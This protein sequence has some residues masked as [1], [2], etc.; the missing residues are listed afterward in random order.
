MLI[1]CRES[2]LE[3]DEK[4]VQ[5][6][7]NDLQNGGLRRRGG[8]IEMGDWDSDDDDDDADERRRRWEIR[9]E[10]MKRR[11][12]EDENLGRLGTSPHLT[13]K[14][15]LIV[16]ANPKAQAFLNAI[17]STTTLNFDDE[18]D[19]L[20]ES[21]IIEDTRA[22]TLARTNSM[23]QGDSQSQSQ[24]ADSLASQ[25]EV[26]VPATSSRSLT[27]RTRDLQ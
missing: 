20:G 23:P 9:R 14:Y 2:E 3:R 6:L 11:M 22:G 12:L 25:T 13:G 19:F 4:F 1:M 15:L 7:M 10:E 8:G 21:D 18:P 26:Q 5:G 27:R 24:L 16:A 17:S